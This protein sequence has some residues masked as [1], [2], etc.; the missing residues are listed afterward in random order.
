M[1]S[2]ETIRIGHLSDLHLPLPARVPLSALA[3]KR[4]IGWTNARLI[5]ARAHRRRPVAA[6]LEHLA[7]RDPD[8]VVITGDL[9]SLALDFEYAAVD[10]LLRGAGLRPENTMLLP[11]NHDRYTPTADYGRSF[12]RG[13]AAWLPAGFDARGGWPRCLRAGP[14]S[15]LGLDTAVWRGPLRAAGRLGAGQTARLERLAAAEAAAGRQLVLAM[16]H[17][18]FRLAG[19][20]WRQYRTGLAGA[21]RLAALLG[22]WP[23]TVLCGHLH[24]LDRRRLGRAQVICAPSASHLGHDPHLQAAY[25]LYNLDAGGP[26]HAEAVRYR[27]AASGSERF[28]RVELPAELRLG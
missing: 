22:R 19:G 3:G 20:R 4:L 9:V 12:E 14:V 15:L 23:A 24:R 26:Q 28:E 27:P 2:R 11:G 21:R 17:P 8:L 6:L 10:V 18:P 5:R 16:H 7:A 13:L 25:H 1:P